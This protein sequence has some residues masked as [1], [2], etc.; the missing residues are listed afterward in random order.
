MTHGMAP[1][2]TA[3]IHP[4]DANALSGAVEAA[5]LG[6][7]VAVL[8]GPVAKIRK[9]AAAAA[10]DLSGYEIIDAEHSEAAAQA[11][12]AMAGNGQ[13]EA[14]MKG[15]LHTDELMRAIL[16]P[17]ARLRTARRMSHVFAIDAPG[18]PRPLFITDAALN[19]Y[20]T[21]DEKRDI[22]QNAI[23]LAHA[24]GLARPRV[25][26]LS[27]RWRLTMRSRKKRPRSRELSPKSPGWPTSCWCRT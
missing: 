26:L 4:V 2:R 3:V 5:R 12:A 17:Q 23:E 14:L 10:I 22:V 1:L 27:A 25:A 16:M 18:Y 15:G 6:L 21:L 11:G 24:L 7:I 19:L 13:V 20:P 8:V 9:A